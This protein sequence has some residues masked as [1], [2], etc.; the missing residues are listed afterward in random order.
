MYYVWKHDKK[1]ALDYLE[2]KRLRLQGRVK[3]EE[4][5]LLER[6]K[7]GE[8]FGK[9]NPFNALSYDEFMAFAKRFKEWV[10]EQ[11]G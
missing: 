2:E 6:Y 11:A 5:E 1:A 3:P 4:W 9:Q 8:R 10:G 7:N